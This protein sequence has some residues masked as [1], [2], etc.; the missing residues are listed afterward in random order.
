MTDSSIE[1]RDRV[2]SGGLEAASAAPFGAPIAAPKPQQKPEVLA[3]SLAM[4]IHAPVCS[5][6]RPL[7][8]AVRT[9]LPDPCGS[10]SAKANAVTNMP[11]LVSPATS[12]ARCNAVIH[13]D[14]GGIGWH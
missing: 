7:I 10:L 13:A 3:N 6:V 5:H 12:Y 14:D 9:C 11:V 1:M 2:A 8:Y 4:Q